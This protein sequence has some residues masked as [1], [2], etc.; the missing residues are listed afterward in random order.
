MHKA[1][2]RQQII[3]QGVSPGF[4]FT[5]STSRGAAADV[6]SAAP[7]GAVTQSTRTPSARALG[8]IL[9]PLRGLGTTSRDFMPRNPPLTSGY[10]SINPVYSSSATDMDT[11]AAKIFSGLVC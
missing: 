1:A 2:K 4:D 6:E 5:A 10:L 11:S 9:T 7:C 8:Y 3:A